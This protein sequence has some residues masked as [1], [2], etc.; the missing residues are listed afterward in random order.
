MKKLIFFIEFFKEHF[1]AYFDYKKKLDFS[2]V[3][4]KQ[5]KIFKTLFFCKVLTF[6]NWEK[7]FENFAKVYEIFIWGIICL[8]LT[9]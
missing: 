4:D 3:Q 8:T 2:F 9:F 5:K 1:L 7:Y 6:E